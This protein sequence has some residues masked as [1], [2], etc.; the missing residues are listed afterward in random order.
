MT[1]SMT[2]GMTIG[3]RRTMW[4]MWGELIGV[5]LVSVAAVIGVAAVML[6][7]P[8]VFTVFKYV[9]GTYLFYLGVQLWLSLGKMAITQKPK[10]KEISRLQ[11]A[12]QGFTTAVANPKGWAFTISL[13]PPFIN[14]Q[15]PM[16]PQ[17]MVLLSIILIAEFICLM[18]YASGGQSLSKMLQ[19]R[20]NIQLLNRVAGSLMCGVGC[21]L[22]V[23]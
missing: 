7:Y 3:L 23:G 13:L 6:H 11:L 9:G 2:L 4:M 19:R 14:A 1:L 15:E 12:V 17:L 5:A 20:G 22:V 21:W 18:L 10:I 8:A 16:A